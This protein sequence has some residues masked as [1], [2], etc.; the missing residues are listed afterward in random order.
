M[1]RMP[2]HFGPRT[3]SARVFWFTV[4]IIFVVDLLLMMSGLGRQWRCCLEDRVTQAEAAVMVIAGQPSS[5]SVNLQTRDV[6]SDLSGIVAIKLTGGNEATAILPAAN[7]LWIDPEVDLEH[8]GFWQSAWQADRE[9]LGICAP[10]LPVSATF[11]A[12]ANTHIEI[13]IRERT[14]VAHLRGYVVR[15]VAYS[16]IVSGLTG[17]LVYA[18]LDRLLVKPM[19]IM[20]ANIVAFRRDPEYA[21]L[22]GLKWLSRKGNNEIS[23]AARELVVMQEE[24]RTALWRNAQLAALG[25]AIAKISHDLRNILSGALLVAARF[26]TNP[27]PEIKQAS[28]SLI[29][30][31][32]RAVEL[33]TQTLDSA[34]GRPP[35]VSRAPVVLRELVDEVADFVRQGETGMATV[36]RVPGT[37]I[38]PLDRNQIYRVLANLLRNAAEAQASRAVVTTEMENGV[39][40]L[41]VADNGPGLPRKALAGLFKPFAGSGRNGGTGLGLAIARDLVRAHGGDLLLRKTGPEGTEFILSLPNRESTGPDVDTAH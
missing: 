27:D 4:T 7:P 25:T 13:I 26:Q 14:L 30:S 23:S 16:V 12:A 8:V 10:F 28:S 41:V 19:R 3:L 18:A 39:T 40:Q 2:F 33:V 9:V 11:P 36:N 35:P 21:R 34:G 37:L 31:I 17:G 38:L 6:L 1:I 5:N 24:L 20:T 22:S 32:E 15:M 29:A